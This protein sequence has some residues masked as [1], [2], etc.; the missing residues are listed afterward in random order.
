MILHNL[1]VSFVVFCQKKQKKTRSAAADDGWSK[2][3][4]LAAEDPMDNTSWLSFHH[5][6]TLMLGSTPSAFSMSQHFSHV[7]M[8]A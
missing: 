3:I 8:Q 6:K 4:L 2:T 5:S 1:L 7:M